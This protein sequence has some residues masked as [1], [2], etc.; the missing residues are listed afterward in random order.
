V[1]KL[2]AAIGGLANRFKKIAQISQRFSEQIAC[3]IG[4]WQR[5][6]Y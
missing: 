1:V 2:R 5:H 3:G 6:F 4:V